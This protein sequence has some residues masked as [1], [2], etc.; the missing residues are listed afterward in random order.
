MSLTQPENAYLIRIQNGEQKELV[1]IT[2]DTE[3]TIGRAVENKISLLDDRCSR[4]HAKIY[5]D[6]GK[7]FLQDLGSRNG[8]SV[9]EKQVLSDAC[10]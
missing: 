5:F 7:W 8:T 9:D 3:I 2:S 6:S 4:F 10:E 1:P